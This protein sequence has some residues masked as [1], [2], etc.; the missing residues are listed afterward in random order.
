M[1]L[2]IQ[3][4]WFSVSKKVC[5]LSHSSL[6]VHVLSGLSEAFTLGRTLVLRCCSQKEN[7]AGLAVSGEV[8]LALFRP[9][10]TVQGN[11]FLRF[12]ALRNVCFLKDCTGSRESLRAIWNCISS[13]FPVS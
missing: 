1:A 11:T 9:F 5:V 8:C 4:T 6:F 3:Q 10:G 2:D 12:V 7:S 13:L